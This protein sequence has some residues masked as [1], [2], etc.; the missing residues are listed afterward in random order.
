MGST[1]IL[2]PYRKDGN[3]NRVKSSSEITPIIRIISKCEP[4]SFFFCSKNIGDTLRKNDIVGPMVQVM[5]GI[6]YFNVNLGGASSSFVQFIC[7][8]FDDKISI[9]K[10]L[11]GIVSKQAMHKG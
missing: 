6:Y 7:Y 3:D 5:K 11:P 4:Y 1:I 9:I 8:E 2:W 10:F